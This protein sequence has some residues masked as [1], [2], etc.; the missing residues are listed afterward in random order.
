MRNFAF[1]VLCGGEQAVFAA[2]FFQQVFGFLFFLFQRGGKRVNGLLFFGK[3]LLREQGGGDEIAAVA[4]FADFYFPLA[5]FGDGFQFFGFIPAVAADEIEIIGKGAVAVIHQDLIDVVGVGER[6]VG[7]GGKQ[8]FT[9]LVYQGLGAVACPDL[10]Q[11]VVLP[12]CCKRRGDGAGK[13]GV[14]GRLV[15]GGFLS[16]QAVL[17]GGCG[18][19]LRWGRTGRF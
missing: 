19:C 2:V 8:A 3:V 15:E 16:P 1:V 18:R 4:G 13:G 17:A 10:R 7:V 9:Q 12:P 5:A 11:S 14:C 6:G